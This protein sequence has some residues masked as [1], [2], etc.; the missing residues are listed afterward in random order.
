[1][2]SARMLSEESSALRLS[3]SDCSRLERN[4]LTTT[5]STGSALP[6]GALC[7]SWVTARSA[8]GRRTIRPLD[9]SRHHF[10]VGAAGQHTD[11]LF[12]VHVAGDGRGAQAVHRLRGEKNTFAGLLRHAAQRASDMGC[13]AMVIRVS[14]AAA[15]A[16]MDRTAAPPNKTE[17]SA[18]QREIAMVF[19]LTRP[20]VDRRSRETFGTRVSPPSPARFR[21]V[22]M[23]VSPFSRTATGSSF[24]RER[25]KALL[26]PT[27]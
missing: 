5:A 8:K 18:L 24:A 15:A 23:R 26:S 7:G 10:Q 4:P 11:G 20:L 27:R 17:R 21:R 19:P 2:S 9:P 12:G 3:S 1:M 22:S 13:S 25:A 14:W 16:L 6:P